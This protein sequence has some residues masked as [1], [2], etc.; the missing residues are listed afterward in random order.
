M[1][2]SLI[3]SLL[4]FIIFFHSSAQKKSS[5]KLYALSREI[6]SGVKQVV[7]DLNGKEIKSSDQNSIQYYIYFECKKK[8]AFTIKIFG[9]PTSSY[10]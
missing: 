4:F 5:A 6:Y 9:Y 7:I 1:K 8:A 10:N 3:I 2:K